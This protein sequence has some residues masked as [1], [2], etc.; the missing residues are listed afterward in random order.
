MKKLLL[1]FSVLFFSLNAC[2]K[3]DLITREYRN[4]QSTTFFSLQSGTDSVIIRIAQYLK[5]Q[6]EL[7][8]FASG[9]SKTDGIPLWNKSIITSE[10]T[11]QFNTVRTQGINSRVNTEQQGNQDTVVFIPLVPEN[12]DY[13][14]SFIRAVSGKNGIQWKLFSGRDYD[15]FPYGDPNTS[16]ITAEKLA[17]ITMFLEHKAFGSTKFEL[18]ND[19]LFNKEGIIF[20]AKKP[21]SLTLTLGNEN[22]VQTQAETV[23][24]PYCYTVTYTPNCTCS[25]ERLR[26]QGCDQCDVCRSSTT[27]YCSYYA[28][29]VSSSG[30]ST[31]AGTG[32]SSGGNT[33]GGSSP[34]PCDPHDPD[35]ECASLGWQE[36]LAGEINGIVEMGAYE[37]SWL[38]AHPAESFQILESLEESSNPDPIGQNQFPAGFDNEAIVAARMT[39]ASG[40]AGIVTNP[41]STAF[42]VVSPYMPQIASFPGIDHS[43]YS[44]AFAI[45]CSTIKAE[46]PNWPPYKVYFEACMDIVHFGLDVVGLFPIVGE[47][48]DFV[49][50]AMYLVQGDGV[51]ATTSFLSMVPVLGWY[52]TTAKYARKMI[53]A[54]DGTK[55]TLKWAK[56]SSSIAFGARSQLRKVLGLTV[57]DPR[58]AHHIIPWDRLSHPAIQMAAKAKDPFHMNELL[59]GTALGFAQHSGNHSIYISKVTEKL[60]AIMLTPG[61]TPDIA[62]TRVNELLLLIKNAIVSQGVNVD[63]LI[64]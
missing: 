47:F 53:I 42:S 51:N 38:K 40:I 17:L 14:Y 50:G 59:N 64:F 46:H 7:R 29:S 36:L 10:R 63:Q 39:I 45:L 21:R 27:N 2:R 44:I 32:G 5:S 8:E 61:I 54:V 43:A 16:E 9:L 6:N 18:T 23:F 22:N 19:K 13:V 48:A 57:G 62:R 1:L 56:A 30:T 55:R 12:T 37:K 26:T 33:G 41:S 28:L 3:P 34:E 52:T 11:N 31:G 25:D 4:I 60:D 58:V 20:N 15:R 35:S 49:N 24:I